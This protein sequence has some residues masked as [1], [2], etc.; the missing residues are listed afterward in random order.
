MLLSQEYVA[1]WSG[2]SKMAFRFL[3]CYF[4]AYIL[5]LFCGALFESPVIWIGQNVL[6]IDYSF[7][8]N[9]YGSGD[10]TFA[11]VL[12][13]IN[14]SIA[15]LATFFW[16]ILNQKAKAYNKILYWF[17]IVLRV[18]LIC[19]MFLYG[20]V[21]VFQ[22]QFPSPSLIRL[23]EP[24]GN[25]SPMGLAWTYMGYSKGF[26]MFAGFMEILGA[27]LLIPKRT[28]TLGALVIIGVMLQ[29]AVMNFMFDIPVK[30]LSVHLILMAGVIFITDSKRFLQVFIKNEA[31]AAYS[32]YTP[33]TDTSYSNTI[34]WVKTIGLILLIGMGILFGSMTEKSR[35]D[36]SDRP[37]LYG[38]WEAKLVVQNKDTLPPLIT[39]S[40]RWR[41]LIIDKKNSAIVK[42][43]D[44]SKSYFKFKTDTVSQSISMYSLK[45]DTVSNN[46][47]Y[48][49]PSYSVLEI[50]GVLEN[51]SV[52]IFLQRKNLDNFLLKSRG[53]HWINERPL[54]K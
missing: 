1:Q 22:I 12:L 27:L 17:L 11:Y 29:V 52:A 48:S 2:T 10:N 26:G 33:V 51:D 19:T 49:Y 34:F 30:L 15:I 18:S 39:D 47:N 44:N 40:K 6:G 20:F 25:F 45:K 13:F 36:V 54:N 42:H 7:E 37:F 31:T 38:I 50:E 5:L 16:F 4:A 46:L 9:G 3:F 23:M 28:Q 43:M 21:K 8:A 24:L 14:L 32:Y 53:F 35:S 41:Y